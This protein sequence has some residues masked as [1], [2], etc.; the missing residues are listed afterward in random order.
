MRTAEIGP[1]LRLAQAMSLKRESPICRLS[2]TLRVLRLEPDRSVISVFHSSL[3][4]RQTGEREKR[5]HA[6]DDG[7]RIGKRGKAR[8]EKA[9]KNIPFSIKQQITGLPSFQVET[10]ESVL[11]PAQCWFDGLQGNK[12]PRLLSSSILLYSSP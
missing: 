11:Y 4:H 2:V 9:A 12:H 7:K 8:P 5:K 3:C 10:S 6:R 1:D